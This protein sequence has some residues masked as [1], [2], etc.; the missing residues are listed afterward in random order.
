MSFGNQTLTFFDYIAFFLAGALLANGVPHFVKG[1]CGEKFATPLA[2]MQGEKQSSALVNVIWGWI[3]F[4]IGAWLLHHFSPVRIPP[5]TEP[6]MTAAFGALACAVYLA[7]RFGKAGK[8][9]K[10]G[11][12]T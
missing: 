11:R 6:C 3:N 12:R 8:R 9:K 1:I 4:A 7:W 2:L 5:A 10:K